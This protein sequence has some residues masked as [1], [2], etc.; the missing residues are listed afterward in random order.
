MKFNDSD[1]LVFSLEE[2]ENMDEVLGSLICAG[3][4]A[5]RH[6]YTIQTKSPGYSVPQSMIDYCV[7]HSL[8]PKH[9]AY[10]S[11]NLDLAKRLWLTTLDSMIYAFEADYPKSSDF[12]VKYKSEE[13]EPGCFHFTPVDNGDWKAYQKALDDHNDKVLRGREQFAAHFADL[14]L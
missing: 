8:F 9:L 7:A 12:K 3:L 13:K 11:K 14:W 5:Y 1:K 6:T 4:V 2:V 10:S